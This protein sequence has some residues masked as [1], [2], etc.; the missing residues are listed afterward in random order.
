MLMGLRGDREKWHLKKLHLMFDN[1]ER[2][3]AKVFENFKTIVGGRLFV[4]L[5]FDRGLF[6]KDVLQHLYGEV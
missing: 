1:V 6:T 2:D 3:V 4:Y 5:Y